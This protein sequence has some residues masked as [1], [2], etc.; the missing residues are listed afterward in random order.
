MDLGTLWVDLGTL[1]VGSGGGDLGLTSSR[2]PPT[3]GWVDG[4][5]DFG[6]GRM[7]ISL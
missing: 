6:V 3:E 1:W 5:G 2:S 4:S 7:V